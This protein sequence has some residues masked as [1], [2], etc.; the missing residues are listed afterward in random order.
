[1]PAVQDQTWYGAL[2]STVRPR[3]FDLTLASLY[4]LACHYPLLRPDRRL[5][6]LAA[7]VR[8]TKVVNFVASAPG[9]TT[10]AP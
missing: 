2:N 7:V 5:V 9:F 6:E 8:V 4:W 10:R 1:M 3:L